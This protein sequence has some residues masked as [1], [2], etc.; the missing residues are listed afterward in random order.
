MYALRAVAVL[1]FLY[2]TALRVVQC[3]RSYYILRYL[4]FESNIKWGIF[5]IV[6]NRSYVHK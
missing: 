5:R 4:Q 1:D 2:N 6:Q 3:E